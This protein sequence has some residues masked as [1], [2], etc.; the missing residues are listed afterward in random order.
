MVDNNINNNNNNIP[1]NN[2]NKKNNNTPQ[3][4]RTKK[5]KFIRQGKYGCVY[6][7]GLKT[8]KKTKHN[9][10]NNN[11]TKKK[12]NKKQGKKQI[13]KLL[14]KKSADKEKEFFKRIDTINSTGKYHIKLDD[15]ISK[16]SEIASIIHQNNLAE[17]KDGKGAYCSVLMKQ[18]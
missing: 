8:N 5:I 10:Q 1:Q 4:K 14:T 2:N 16:Q 12:Q 17:L 7:P 9:T 13:S 15:E 18:E 3:N 6:K 11:S